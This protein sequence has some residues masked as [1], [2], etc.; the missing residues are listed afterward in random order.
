MARPRAGA[1][2]AG[3]RILFATSEAAPLI[4]TGGLADVSQA[5]PEALTRLGA[6]V[7]VLL[8][9]YPQVLERMVVTIDLAR[10]DALI[11][12]PPA[13]L[14]YAELPGGVPLLLLDCP[15][16][17]DR[18]GGPYQ[19]DA[20]ADWPDNAERFGLLSRVAALLVGPSTPLPWRPNV[21]HCHDWQTGLAPAYVT[22]LEGHA[23]PSVMTIHNLAYQGIVPPEWVAKLGLPPESFSI[24]GVEYYGSLSFLKAGLFY[25]DHLTTVSP[26]YAQEIQTEPLGFGLQGL[27][28]TRAHELTGILNGID[29]TVWNPAKDE[30]LAATYD[31]RRLTR[32]SENK[33]ALQARMELEERDD[34]PLLAL[35]SRFTDQKGVDLLLA[36]AEEILSIPAQLALLGS[37]DLPLEDASADLAT[38]HR[39]RFGFQRGFDEALSHLIE[40]GADIFLMPSRFEP[41]GLNQ[42]YSQRYGTPPVVHA[43]GGLIDSVVDVTEATLADG[44]GSGFAF[45]P[46]EPA[47]FLT[48]IQRAVAAWKDKKLWRTIQHNGMRK[49][50]SWDASARKYVEVYRG[51]VAARGA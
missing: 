20:G 26:S 25:A 27:L 5:L 31:A 38:L 19:D 10:I 8:P 37:G 32:K 9:A 3:L 36:V 4:K 11:P 18:P 42:M 51:V 23:V 30:S 46:A 1:P 33:R 21:L 43:T 16:L 45:T 40:A 28:T 29:T 24:N 39:G 7:R 34:L 50:F 47:V 22:F 49:D 17:Y 6:D 48:A 13:G 15:D 2:G 14:L 35:V 12:F 41:C 44:T